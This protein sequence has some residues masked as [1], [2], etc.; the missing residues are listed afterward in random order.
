MTPNG[1]TYTDAQRKEFAR[2]LANREI[3]RKALSKESGISMQTLTVWKQKFFPQ[4]LKVPTT[5]TST[6]T[7][8]PAGHKTRRTFTAAQKIAAVK[9]VIGGERVIDVLASLGVSNSV[10]QRWRKQFTEQTRKGAS[11]A[12]KPRIAT[13]HISHPDKIAA[14]IRLES[15]ERAVDIANS[16]GVSRSAVDNWRTLLRREARQAM[17]AGANGNAKT[18]S[19]GEAPTINESARIKHAIA[20]LRPLAEKQVVNWRDPFHLRTMHA[21][22]ILEGNDF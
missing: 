22:A 2:R 19:N 1:S 6:S 8:K 21:L 15:G 10:M 3:T 12:G 17:K 11:R 4:P 18:M 5:S 14:V 20:L 16:I 7:T 13:K 9:R